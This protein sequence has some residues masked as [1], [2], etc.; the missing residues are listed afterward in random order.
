[1]EEMKINPASEDTSQWPLP[2]AICINLE[3]MRVES[4]KP[5]EIDWKRHVLVSDLLAS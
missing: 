4:L 1:M 2:E 5:D 3:T